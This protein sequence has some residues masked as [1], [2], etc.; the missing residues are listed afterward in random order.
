MLEG[1]K[2]I[3]PVTAVNGNAP[4]DPSFPERVKRQIEEIQLGMVHRPPRP[5]DPWLEGLDICIHGHT[6]RWRDQ[7]VDG[8]R[9]IN[10][11]TP[12]AAA[13]SQDRTIAILTVNGK[14][15]QLEK[16]TL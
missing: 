12:T 3:A 8:V 15:A 1:L 6:H 4:D 14:N 7:V 2:Q 13:F 9:M 11:S 10:V 16:I 5:G